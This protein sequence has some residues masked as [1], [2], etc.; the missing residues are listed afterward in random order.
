MGEAFVALADDA[1]SLHYNPAGLAL[2]P[3]ALALPYRRWDLLV[4]HS[5]H[6]RDIRLSQLGL[7]RKPFGASLTYLTLDGI[8]RRASETALPENTFGASDLALGVTYAKTFAGVGLGATLKG[9]QQ[10]IDTRSATAFA[11]DLGTLYRLERLPVT[12]GASLSNLGTQVRFVDEAFPLPLLLRVGAS[13]GMTSS[14]PIAL[15]AQL[16]LPRDSS[17]V[18][19]LGMEYVGFGP[20]VLRAGYMA[21]S[22]QQRDVLLGRSLGSS[23]TGLSELFGV[24]MGAGFRIWMGSLDYSFVPYGELGDAH[25]FSMSLRF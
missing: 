19:R 5:L 9:V 1:S 16:D 3:S 17:P 12:L 18:Y 8:E 24:T 14:F 23:T 13:A 25:R 22:S 7:M 10:R 4:S 6:V 20:F 11:L 15:S 21:A 2:S